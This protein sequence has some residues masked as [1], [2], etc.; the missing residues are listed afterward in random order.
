VKTGGSR[1]WRQG[2]GDGGRSVPGEGQR[3]TVGQRRLGHEGV[4]AD[5]FEGKRD[6]RHTGRAAPRRRQLSGDAHRCQPMQAGEMPCSRVEEQRGGE[7][8]LG[9]GMLG[10]GHGR[11]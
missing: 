3:G 6:R 9:D 7:G 8:K 5:L 10:L 11:R 2:R 4:A 1:P